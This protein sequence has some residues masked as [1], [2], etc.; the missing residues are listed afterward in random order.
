[1]STY[2]V[3]DISL[4]N[5]WVENDDPLLGN[6]SEKERARGGSNSVAQISFPAGQ[7]VQS[8]GPEICTAV[9]TRGME[10]R[11]SASRHRSRRETA[12]LTCESQ[13]FLTSDVRTPWAKSLNHA[14]GDCH[15]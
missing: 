3:Q 8:A 11:C 9:P 6:L 14:Q 4:N 10:H 13:A 2:P 15:D 12:A 5:L 7:M 1:M